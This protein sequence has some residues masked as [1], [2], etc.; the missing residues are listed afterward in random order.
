MTQGTGDET[1][2]SPNDAVGRVLGEEHSGRVRCMG[3]GAAP[4]NTF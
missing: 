2:A 1:E 3:M 4:A